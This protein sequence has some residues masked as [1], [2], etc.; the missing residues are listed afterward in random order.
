MS[1]SISCPKC[2]KS[3]RLPDASY[4]GKVGKCSKCEHKFVLAL[5][6]PEPDEV[7]LELV[8]TP[9]PVQSTVGQS[10]AVESA[11]Q[12]GKAA[13]W[14]PD[15]APVAGFPPVFESAHS[16]APV[17]ADTSDEQPG[18]LKR[19]R[20]KSP[21]V[22]QVALIAAI[23]VLAGGAIAYFALAPN[24]PNSKVAA[25]K[26][27][28]NHSTS[29][30]QEVASADS[31]DAGE[32]PAKKRASSGPT[33][34]KFGRPTNGKPIDLLW[35]PSGA[36][37]VIN[38][39]PAELWKAGGKG[40]GEFIAALGPLGKSL[41]S[42]MVDFLKSKPQEI[43][44][45]LLCVLPGPRTMPPE[46]AAVVRRKPDHK[47]K[48]SDLMEGLT[49]V[50][51]GSV[52]YYANEKWAMALQPDLMTYAI[53]PASLGA[54][55]AKAVTRPNPTANEIENLLKFTDRT[56][57]FTVLFVPNVLS[58]HGDVLVPPNALSLLESVRSWI[59]SNDDVECAAWSFHITD[60]KFYSQIML[61]NR[62]QGERGAVKPQMVAKSFQT[63]LA[64]TPRKVLDLIQMMN[65]KKI[66]NRKIIGRVPAMVKVVQMGTKV[67]TDK[68]LVSLVYDGPERAAPN[69]ALGTLLAWDESTRTNFSSSAADAAS[70]AQTQKPLKDLLKTKID[71]DFR[72]QPLEDALNFIAGE[73]KFKIFVDGDG[74]KTVAYTKN[75][76]QTLKA[77]GIS[78]ST[79]MAMIQ[80]K[81][82][83]LC[84]VLDEEKRL[85]TV[86]VTEKAKA[87][88]L[89]ITE[90]K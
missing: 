80:A 42:L 14:V 54:E 70:L 46:Y 63:Q 69:L 28:A 10:A 52:K 51:S 83:K 22:Q 78:A 15:E 29:G 89:K 3:L 47:F 12:V 25:K 82:D 73:A 60:Q 90:L 85:V 11:P 4:L 32:S 61:R 41:E 49:P 55:M 58:T 45:L 38:M 6:E 50:E 66:G 7:P 64:E 1:I 44:E 59:S 9:P 65:P 16:A 56:L 75:M 40:E 84:F 20:K 8:K 30:S 57:H 35:I 88:N 5:P 76:P 33:D 72:A 26:A 21:L 87:Q 67:Q 13:E 24:T 23:A 71:I 37:I 81:L 43:D 74:L 18:R 77:E 36:R 31:S 27:T 2:G 39:R 48:K 79:A 86:T 34:H 17:F 19:K 53:A 68:Q 62:T